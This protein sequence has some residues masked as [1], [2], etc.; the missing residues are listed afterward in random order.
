[1]VELYVHDF[2][3][4]TDSGSDGS[5]PSHQDIST[6]PKTSFYLIT[7]ALI[8][9]YDLCSPTDCNQYLPIYPI[10]FGHTFTQTQTKAKTDARSEAQH[11]IRP[12]ELEDWQTARRRLGSMD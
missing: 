10:P 7:R 4:D 9:D 8:I 12:A 6:G 5:T 11:A 1:M 2:D 3:S